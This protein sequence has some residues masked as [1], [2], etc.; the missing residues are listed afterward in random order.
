MGAQQPRQVQ[1]S[2]AKAL[3]SHLVYSW[4]AGSNCQGRN[5]AG[6]CVET[7]ACAYLGTY[8]RSYYLLVRCITALSMRAHASFPIGEVQR[9]TTSVAVIRTGRG[10]KE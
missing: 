10:K 3:P 5:H 4:K 1:E 8:S 6:N 9:N 2:V 7:E